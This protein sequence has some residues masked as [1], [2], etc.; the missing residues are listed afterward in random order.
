MAFLAIISL[1]IF[2]VILSALGVAGG[3]LL[4]AVYSSSETAFIALINREPSVMADNPAIH[5]L[6][7]RML[8][9]PNRL[10]ATLRISNMAMNIWTAVFAAVLTGNLI[11]SY[12]LPSILV[13]VIEIVV[14]ALSILIVSEIIPRIKAVKNPLRTAHK[15]SRLV[16]PFFI[17]LKPF[18]NIVGTSN[19]NADEQLSSRESARTTDELMTMAEVSD[20][21]EPI[22]DEEREIIEN[23]IEFGSTTA[24]EIMTSRVNIEAIATD[25]TLKSVIELIREQGLSRMPIYED[26]LDNI[27]GVIHAKDVLPYIS[28][29]VQQTSI[30]WRII[31]RT[32][33]YVPA[34]KKLDDLL[35]D[36]RQQKTH[37][38]VVVDEYGGT[39]GLVTLDDILEEIVGDISDEYDEGEQKLYRRFKS[40]VY[41]FDARIDLDD[42]ETVLNCSLTSEDD[43]YESLGGLVYYMSERLPNVGERFTFKQLELTVHSV[44]NNRVK[45]VRVKVKERPSSP[46]S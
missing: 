27:L 46:K 30:N 29:D 28:A 39:E 21:G 24:R 4:S 26:D 38:A 25:S 31:A 15:T 41:I 20:S 8:K 34:T 33:L 36:F 5:K 22:K 17:I 37:L 12:E 2:A 45:K 16:Y 18:A 14:V 1:H 44:H 7:S 19:V 3:L 42:M 43:E 9:Q 6:T 32:T 35:R 10:L 13:Y 11:V 23:V 40:G